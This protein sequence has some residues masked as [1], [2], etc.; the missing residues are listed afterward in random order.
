MV[1]FI[2]HSDQAARVTLEK[3]I[4]WLAKTPRNG[5]WLVAVSGGAD[6][7]ALLHLL[8]DAGF[9]NLTVC[10]LNHR[11]RGAA[12][13][14]D[15]RFVA[16]LAKRLDLPCEIGRA[17][18]RARMKANRES[19]ETAARNARHEFFARC[20][21]K[22]GC[23]RVLLAHHA[24]D[25][26]ETVLWNLLRGSHGLKG[27]REE[28]TMDFTLDDRM[29]AVSLIRPLLGSR[30][31]E[32]TDWLASRGLAWREDESNR[33]AVAVRN[34]LRHE[35]FPLLNAISGRDA[36][37]ALTRAAADAAEQAEW[38][39]SLLDQARVRDPQGRLH[40]GA[41]RELHPLLQREALRV[42]LIDHGIQSLDRALLD[43]ALAL[44]D[45][46]SPAVVN[47]RGGARLRRSAGRIRVEAGGQTSIE[48]RRDV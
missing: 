5:P 29:V 20:S 41:L 47:L 4:P 11:L 12:S 3:R 36:V 22:Y 28:Q 27:M 19:M 35:V 13:T 1:A 17:D 25:Q 16:D 45:V 42:F 31:A 30:H 18:V 8:V 26:A 32:L 23:K 33:Q 6:S 37:A 2:R 21:E 9:E 24:D 10:H 14:K 40:L 38:I 44:I 15:A 34:R 43:R 39:K 48:D 46:T 7:V